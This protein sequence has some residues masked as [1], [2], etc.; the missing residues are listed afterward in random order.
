MYLFNVNKIIVEFWIL[1]FQ[2]CFIFFGFLKIQKQLEFFIFILRTYFLFFFNVIQVLCESSYESL[3][4]RTVETAGHK[5]DKKM[6]SVVHV[7]FYVQQVVRIE[8]SSSHKSYTHKAFRLCVSCSGILMCED[9][10]KLF[11]KPNKFGLLYPNGFFCELLNCWSWS[12][13]SDTGHNHMVFL[14]KVIFT[15]N[16]IF[17][18]GKKS[19]L[20]STKAKIN[21]FNNVA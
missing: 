2:F 20:F 12:I 3:T 16:I 18:L 17:V 13:V 21:E 9:L 15:E 19:F 11:H 10:Q 1:L 14:L 5:Q 8:Y 7:F 6:C 4:L